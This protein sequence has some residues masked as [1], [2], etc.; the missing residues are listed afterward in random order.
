[1]EVVGKVTCEFDQL[2][3]P[4]TEVGEGV[5]PLGGR[6]GGLEGGGYKIVCVCVYIYIY[7]YIYLFVLV[8]ID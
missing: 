5:C 6:G 3:G 2:G 4:L 8:F 7:I 1:M